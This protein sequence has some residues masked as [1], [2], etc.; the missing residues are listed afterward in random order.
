MVPFLSLVPN[1]MLL[2][3]SLTD[4]WPSSTRSS[5]MQNAHLVLSGSCLHLR[6]TPAIL[7]TESNIEW[8]E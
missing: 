3:I 2:L 6:I 4:E 1:N 8:C 7:D 5:I